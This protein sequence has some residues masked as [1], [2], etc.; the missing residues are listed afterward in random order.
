MTLTEFCSTLETKL[1]SLPSENERLEIMASGIS[2]AF[3]VKPGEVA[4]FSYDAADE[5][6]HFLWPVKLRSAGKLPYS[7]YSSLAIRT[8]RENRAILDNSF[9]TTPHAAI[10]EQVRLDPE[11]PPLP[12]QKIMSAPLSC[13]E[14]I[15]GVIQVSMKSPDSRSAGNDFTENQLLA[16]V[17][18]AAVVA[19]FI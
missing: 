18:I 2:Q 7:S 1:S 8:I 11:E 12:I 15:K 13:N 5:I 14:E 3:K 6:L 19:R 9:Y 10:F 17:K 16:L 4:I